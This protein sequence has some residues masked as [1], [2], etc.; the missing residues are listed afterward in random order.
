MNWS[1]VSPGVFSKELDGVEKIYHHVSQIFKPIGREH[2]GLYCAC[3]FELG[4][5][6]SQKDTAT[7]LRDA[8]K[9]L[10][11]DFPA[12]A[13]TLDGVHARKTYTVP[14]AS[15]VEK[16]AD[17][18]FVV[19]WTTDPDGVLASYPVRDTPSMYFFPELSQI[20]FLC[21]HW[22]I[23]GLG[24]CLLMDRFFSLLAANT[25][26]PSPESWAN[27]ITKIS[28]TLEDAIKAPTL[29]TPEV[30]ELARKHIEDHH[31]NVVHAGGLRYLG[32]ATTPPGSP[33]RS[34]VTF[35]E[36]TTASL[37]AA[38]KQR[39][40]SVTSAVYAALANAVF[41]LSPD[42]SLEKYA[43][44]MS[45]N[46]R[47]YMPAPY[48]GKDHAVQVYVMGR[49]P[50]VERGSSFAEMTAQFMDYNKGWYNDEFRS[51]YRMATRHH[52]E[53]L[54]RRPKGAAPLNPPSSV[55][56]SSLGIIEKNMP[57]QY[58][59]GAVKLTDFHFGVSMMTRQMLLYVWTFENKLSLSVN[60]NDAYHDVSSIKSFL[61][62][63]RQILKNEIGVSLEL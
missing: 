4:P 57:S 43:A 25:P 7:A 5:R 22:R 56:L 3:T 63:I 2:W 36:T 44:V 18:S 60:Y 37:I 39:S 8:W 11:Y 58:G 27:D 42:A 34:T 41:A 62:Y 35:N 24:T 40:I 6:F 21:S 51:A 32:D 47:T 28:P 38:C 61:E 52:Y 12:L 1:E 33:A 17:E 10:R 53:T 30:Q 48:N 49:S 13:V 19:D 59:G 23:D 45:I 26:S 9:A 16:W 29:E 14:D 54:S 55:T 46:M 31:K 15:S 50:T 20:L